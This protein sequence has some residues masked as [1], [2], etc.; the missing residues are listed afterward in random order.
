M[1]KQRFLTNT[2]SDF[3]P[4]KVGD[5][6][7]E[8]ALNYKTKSADFDLGKT[9]YIKGEE[10][11][12]ALNANIGNKE[13]L[14]RAQDAYTTAYKEAELKGDFE[15]QKYDAG[16]L[17]NELAKKYNFKGMADGYAQEQEDTAWLGE[18]ELPDEW[19]TN[20]NR[21]LIEDNKENRVDEE[22]NFTYS[23]YTPM[24]RKEY[25]EA[26]GTIDEQIKGWVDDGLFKREKDGQLSVQGDLS[27][28]GYGH[29]EKNSFIGRNELIKF[30]KDYMVSNRHLGKSVATEAEVA[31]E[32]ARFLR[33]DNG[34]ELATSDVMAVVGVNS[35]HPPNTPN[36]IQEQAVLAEYVE[37]QLAK[38]KKLLGNTKY[39]ESIELEKIGTIVL[40][41]VLRT[42]YANM[43]ANKHDGV[44]ES[45]D[46]F[47]LEKAEEDAGGGGGSIVDDKVTY[48]PQVLREA[49]TVEAQNIREQNAIAITETKEEIDSAQVEL[50]KLNAEEEKIEGSTDSQRREEL[51]NQIEKKSLEVEYMQEAE[52]A[53]ALDIYETVREAD[54]PD[55]GVYIED[56]MYARYLEDFNLREGVKG[57]VNVIGDIVQ[58]VLMRGEA[59]KPIDPNYEDPMSL[60][61]FTIETK[62]AMQDSP[63]EFV[64]NNVL[65]TF[66][67]ELFDKI[68]TNTDKIVAA[69]PASYGLEF[70]AFDF[71]S[72]GATAKQKQSIVKLQQADGLLK[73]VV[74]GDIN[75]MT[76]RG[77]I[78]RNLVEA[79]NAR[80]EDIKVVLNPTPIFGD[81]AGTM[82]INERDDE[83]KLTGKVVTETVKLDNSNTNTEVLYDTYNEV[84]T[85]MTSDLVLN[86][87][88]LD[89]TQQR[90][91]KDAIDIKN[92]TDRTAIRF[93]ANK[94]RTNKEGEV[95][96]FEMGKETY[97][98][99]TYKMG[100][101]NKNKILMERENGH[102]YL[103]ENGVRTGEMAVGNVVY[104]YTEEDYV[105][106]SLRINQDGST[107]SPKWIVKQGDKTQV[108][109]YLDDKGEY[110]ASNGFTAYDAGN[111]SQVLSQMTMEQAI[112][113]GTLDKDA[114]NKDTL[115]PNPE[116]YVRSF[117]D[118]KAI[119]GLERKLGTNPNL[120]STV[121]G[122]QPL[123]QF[124]GANGVSTKVKEPFISLNN[125]GQNRLKLLVADSESQADSKLVVTGGN[126]SQFNEVEGGAEDSYHKEGLALDIL[127]NS[128][129]MRML[130]LLEENR[131]KYG[132]QHIKADY[133]DRGHVHIVFDPNLHNEDWSPVTT[134]Y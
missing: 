79:N 30:A 119:E 32:N 102:G 112:R 34:Q 123:S 68:K 50:D 27:E 114:F 10:A 60:E 48:T 9:N 14:G 52:I 106:G 29:L 11:V 66:G 73:D 53:P 62:K 113:K 81:L 95:T 44:D 26:F 130:H 17:T 131:E 132:I 31:M 104:G 21:H 33:K 5:V 49:D 108:P 101:D 98:L 20:I 111:P 56:T 6:V 59:T 28:F 134:K 91:F 7:D 43:I 92:I 13:H 127:L 82:I 58:N 110:I 35:I 125:Q 86:N 51:A 54:D 57:G 65:N 40:N 93:N 85:D 42:K 121:K 18:S 12:Q 115:H 47:K 69:E 90:L 117:T 94:F 71:N 105:N 36:Y 74:L 78:V 63:H 55:L 38:R 23:K 116:G 96:N 99:T 46:K 100:S 133:D 129:G 122:Y 97:R 39:N 87:K 88:N 103:M 64:S 83:G 76:T 75:M 67:P 61:E 25:V 16:N 24:Q 124:F 107:V 45:I 1:A 37:K 22:G 15:N 3:T 8:L 2:F 126:R 118:S 120:F 19:K 80:E 70:T 41:D 72:E 89:K 4:H 109:Y 77:E 84:V 128:A